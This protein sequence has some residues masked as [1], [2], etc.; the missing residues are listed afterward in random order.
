M[1][2]FT[3]LGF[4]SLALA[5]ATKPVERDVKEDTKLPSIEDVKYSKID[6]TDVGSIKYVA[7][8]SPS[9]SN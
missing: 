7:A 3:L 4:V 2:F 5:L 6:G 9:L 8:F 1:K